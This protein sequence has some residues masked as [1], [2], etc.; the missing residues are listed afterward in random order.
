MQ[1]QGKGRVDQKKKLFSSI[2]LHEINRGS[3][4]NFLS[5]HKINQA[6]KKNFLLPK[7]Y[8]K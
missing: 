5:L 7:N 1:G 4:K 6:S 2:K 8:I 3:Q